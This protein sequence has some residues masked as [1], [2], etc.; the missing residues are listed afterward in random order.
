MSCS[1][2]TPIKQK[3]K[4]GFGN[5]HSTMQFF[6]GQPLALYQIR[7]CIY[8]HAYTSSALLFKYPVG[9]DNMIG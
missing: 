5:I 6:S 2:S 8:I 7:T 3:N 4:K 1:Y 9:K